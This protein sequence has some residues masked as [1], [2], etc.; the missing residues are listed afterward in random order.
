MSAI[1]TFYVRKIKD[2]TITLEDV[3]PKWKDQVKAELEKESTEV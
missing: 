3:N 1:V 2:G